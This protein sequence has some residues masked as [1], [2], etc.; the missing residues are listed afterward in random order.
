MKHLLTPKRETWLYRVNP[1][2]KFIL[3]M[4]LLAVAFFNRR[5]D[6]A[7]YQTVIYMLLMILF[8]GHSWKRVLLFTAPFI[9]VFISSASSLILFGRGETIWWTW[10]LIKISEESFYHG[11]LVGFKTLC[12]GTLGM[13][14]ALTTQPVLF[15]YAMMQQLRLPAKYAYSFI[16]SI[17]MFPMVFDDFHNRTNALK[18]RGTRY[19]K[20]VRGAYERMSLYAVP[21][22][23]QS[24]RRAQR[25]AV[26]MEAKRFQ[27]ASTRTYFYITRY[28]RT[29]AIFAAAM[30]ILLATSFMMSHYV[31]IFG[32]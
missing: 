5:V 7:L 8:C 21:L 4:V 30:L 31:S 20:G 28:T 1:A 10:G 17:R 32:R 22:L 26:A 24:I 29:D 9:M 16:A 2:F 25:V 15:F 18:V 23:A 12:F 13:V 3:F 6:L 27:I 11:L 19:S 14:F